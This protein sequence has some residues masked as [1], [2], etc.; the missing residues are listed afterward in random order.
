[1]DKILCDALI[2][3]VSVV[4]GQVYPLK[5]DENARGTYIVYQQTGN[6][7]LMT[8][9][10]DTGCAIINYTLHVLSDRYGSGQEATSTAADVCRA[11]AGTIRSG[12]NVQ[13][14]T[15]EGQSPQEWDPEIKAYR[16]IVNISCFVRYEK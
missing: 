4:R 12:V 13:S 16:A 6:T 8:L 15:V 2:S 7:P 9:S 1:M 5:G 10:G 14:V 3:G 11:M